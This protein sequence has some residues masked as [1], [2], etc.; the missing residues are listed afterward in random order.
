MR[1]FKEGKQE[2]EKSTSEE[3]PKEGSIQ[4]NQHI[5]CVKLNTPKDISA[6]ILKMNRNRLTDRKR[7]TSHTDRV[8][9]QDRD[10][11]VL[12]CDVPYPACHSEALINKADIP[13]R[14]KTRARQ[15]EQKKS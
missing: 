7:A 15:K 10:R 4:E 6:T 9:S 2:K 12:V 5:K 13:Y 11:T 14:M 8:E 3:K 1:Q